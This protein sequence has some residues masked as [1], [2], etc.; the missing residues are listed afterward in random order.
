MRG[1]P[2]DN[3]G[4]ALVIVLLVSMVALTAVVAS[5]SVAALG[6]RQTT[7]LERRSTVALFAAESGLNSILARSRS[8]PQAFNAA[9][10]VSI[11]D[12]LEK[13]G[14]ES[15]ALPGGAQV[16]LAV[17]AE[18]DDSVTIRSIG[19]APDGSRRTILQDFVL[20][21]GLIDPSIFADA[22]LITKP[23]L[24]TNSRN[25]RLIG[26]AISEAEWYFHD[27]PLSDA[28][29]G[30]YVD[31]GGVR[32][33]VTAMDGGMVDLDAVSPASAGSISRADSTSA[34]LIP[35]AVT[36]D[37]TSPWFNPSRLPVTDSNVYRVGNT[38]E[39]GDARGTVTAVG[40]SYIDV[41]WDATPSAALEEG[42]PIR[43]LIVSAISEGGCPPP[44][45]QNL[46]DKLPQGCVERD[47]GDLFA[48]TFNGASKSEIWEY[49]QDFGRCCTWPPRDTELSG[50]TWIDNATTGQANSQRLCGEG[51]V[52]INTGASPLSDPGSININTDGCQFEGIIYVIGQLGLQGNLDTFSGTIIVEGPG[53]T[54]VQGGQ[55]NPNTGQGAKALYDPIAIRRAL[56][57]LPPL[58]RSD[59]LVG[60]LPRTWRFGE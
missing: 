39:V 44:N 29:V 52:V 38:I 53:E 15:Y 60:A 34:T 55:G 10:H 41:T 42:T 40:D 4:I 57:S 59:G 14:L 49:A 47:L 21:D 24:R 54:S 31:I 33:V 32:Y 51:V 12:W 7:S 8:G 48:N 58:T 46:A 17:V 23:A 26:R 56:E 13:V 30:E 2:N 19:I 22:A 5:A 20:E 37:V 9:Q 3:R 28:R 50:I 35:F 1:S 6:A 36:S 16:E 27:R 18:I 43:R 25:S 45:T 11:A